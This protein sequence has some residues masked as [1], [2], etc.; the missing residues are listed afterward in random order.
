M[1]TFIPY[2]IVPALYGI[3]FVIARGGFSAA[4]ALLNRRI[5]GKMNLPDAAVRT[6]LFIFLAADFLAAA[7]AAASS[8]DDTVRD[9][10]LMREDYGGASYTRELHVKTAEGETDVAI[11]VAPRRY[12]ASEVEAILSEAAEAAREIMLGGQ[13]EAHVNGDLVFFDRLPDLPVSVIF[14]TSDPELIDWEGRLGDDIP[15]EGEAV[16]VTADL[17]FDGEVDIKRE[18]DTDVTVRTEEISLT[19]FPREETKAERLARLSRV[20]AEKGQNISSDRLLL[21]GSIDGQAAEWS[22]RD[23]GDG[24]IFLFLGGVIAVVFLF[25]KQSSDREAERKR[26]EALRLQFREGILALSSALE[27]GYS[28]ENAFAASLQDL[29]E[30]YG[31]D[32]MITREFAYIV[33]QLRM[34]RTVE[35]LLSGFGVR[36]GVEE[37]EDFAEIFAVSKRSRGGVVSVI[38]H[39]TRVISGKIEVREEILNMTAEKVFEQ[40]IMNLIPFFIVIYVDM[41]SPGFFDCMYTTAV[42]RI[43]M[44]VCLAVYAVS[45]LL[46][47]RFLQIEV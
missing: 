19:V 31:E 11:E 35:S 45:I 23:S 7:S 12:T 32:G 24:L 38:S 10:Y 37:I 4:A 6:A 44:T 22:G 20:N 17:F 42:G 27:S 33:Q 3:L 18:T 16:T 30:M 29:R 15:A 1:R 36:S 14:Q 26:R 28:V 8:L 41:T 25:A 5:F 9:G 13:K 40:R 47:E 2:L 39:V 34:N 21:P 43:V 46:A